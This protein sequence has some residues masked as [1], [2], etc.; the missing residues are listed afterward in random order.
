M[1]QI[2]LQHPFVQTDTRKLKKG[3]L[4]FALKGEHFNGNHFAKQ[5]LDAGAA[6]AVVDETV[7][8]NDER[9]IH[10]EDSLKALQMLA[11]HHRKQLNIPLLAITGSNG[12]TTTKELIH[13][14]LS[15]HF[16]TYTTEGNLNNHIGIPLT[17]LKIKAD[18]EIAVVEMGANHQKEIEGYCTYT[19]PTHGLITNIGKAHLEGFGGIEGVKKGKGELFDFIRT[20]KGTVFVNTDYEVLAD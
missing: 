12:K 9:I 8:L 6:Y 5:A 17:L 11:M 18:A 13:A 16:I 20:E 14:V 2:F 3:D 10:V 15:S 7:N 19:L 4:F 1:Y